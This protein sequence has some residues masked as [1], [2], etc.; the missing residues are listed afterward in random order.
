MT[1]LSVIIAIIPEPWRTYALAALQA[2][3]AVVLVSS[4]ISAHTPAWA[5]ARWPLLR[6][7]SR[8][9]ALTPR[10][11]A[12]TVKVPGFAPRDPG[13]LAELE[14]LRAAAERVAAVASEARET[15]APPAPV[16]HAGE[17]GAL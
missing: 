4:V 1:D 17:R 15:V 16:D 12:G 5:F 8:L 3:A 6:I 7:F 2:L 9:A 13:A 14:R 10:D 11:G